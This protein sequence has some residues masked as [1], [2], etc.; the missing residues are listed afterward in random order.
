M[1]NNKEQ[2]YEGNTFTKVIEGTKYVVRFHYS[3]NAKETMQQKVNRMLA[4]EVRQAVDIGLI[5]VAGSPD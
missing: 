4:N 2:A 1:G 5:S 3:E